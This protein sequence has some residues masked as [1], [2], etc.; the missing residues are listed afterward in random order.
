VG[1][2]RGG[3]SV[4]EVMQQYSL[5]LQEVAGVDEHLEWAATAA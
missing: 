4:D 2:L 5:T 3:D 1:S